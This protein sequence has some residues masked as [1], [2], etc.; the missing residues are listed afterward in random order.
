MKNA[1]LSLLDHILSHIQHLLNNMCQKYKIHVFVFLYQNPTMFSPSD[2]KYD[3]CLCRFEPADSVMSRARNNLLQQ[4]QLHCHS[5]GI[6]R[7]TYM[8]AS[9]QGATEMFWLH[10]WGAVMSLQSFC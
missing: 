5:V 4:Q 8:A 1:F 6:T 3:V 10:F 7:M 2:T 9:H